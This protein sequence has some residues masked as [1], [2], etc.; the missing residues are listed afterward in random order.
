M[1][2]FCYKWKTLGTQSVPSNPPPLPP[3]KLKTH[4][5]THVYVLF[6]QI[7]SW[8]ILNFLSDL[9]ALRQCLGMFMFATLARELKKWLVI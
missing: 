4:V 6:M 3:A 7:S 9:Y 8:H 2:F 5:A 1:L